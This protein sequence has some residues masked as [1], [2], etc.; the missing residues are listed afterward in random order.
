MRR[1]EC[2]LE[3]IVVLCG[4]PLTYLEVLKLETLLICRSS[5]SVNPVVRWISSL[6][7]PLRY[8]ANTLRLTFEVR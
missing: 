4:I 8:H 5:R 1:D 7:L 3:P 6:V 2:L